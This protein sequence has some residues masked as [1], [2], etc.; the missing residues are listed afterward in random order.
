MFSFNCA[1]KHRFILVIMMNVVAE[2][3]IAENVVAH[4]DTN[5]LY[6]EFKYFSAVPFGGIEGTATTRGTTHIVSRVI[7]V[8]YITGHLFPLLCMCLISPSM[9]QWAHM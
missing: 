8:T 9:I 4:T 3:V 5:R 2:K 6:K 1:H 7:A